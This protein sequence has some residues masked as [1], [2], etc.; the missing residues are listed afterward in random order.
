MNADSTT[1]PPVTATIRSYLLRLSMCLLPLMLIPAAVLAEG[2]LPDGWTSFDGVTTTPTAPRV[3]IVSSSS[4]RIQLIIS[5]PG[6]LCETIEHDGTDYT[7]LSF[8]EYF[9][10]TETGD[11]ALPAIR[12]LL[13]V[14]RGC[15]INVSTTAMDS[16]VFTDCVVYPV[17][18]EVVRYTEEGWSYVDYEFALNEQAY[19]RSGGYPSPRISTEA[20][21]SFRGQ[22]VVNLTSYPVRFD[23]SV[24]E[25][26]VYPELLVTLD[27]SG[28]SGGISE[29]LGP[30]GRIA[31]ELLLGYAGVGGSGSRISAGDGRWG[32]HS[33]VVSCADSFTDYL[34]IV[35][36]SLMVSPRILQLAEHRAKYNGYNVAVVPRTA[37][38]EHHGQGA[39]SDTAIHHFIQDLYLYGEGTAEHM[40]DGR[41]GYVLLVGDAR[42][43]DHNGLNT[44]LPAHEVP[45]GDSSFTTDHWYAC[46]DG[47]TDWYPDLMIGRLCASDTTEL[48]REVQKFVS[49]ETNASSSDEWRSKILLTEGFCDTANPDWI[50]EAHAAFDSIQEILP[51]SW[52]PAEEAH[53]NE[54][55]SEDC[56]AQQ[57]AVRDIHVDRINS[58]VHLLELCAHG[59]THECETF[60]WGYVDSLE[61]DAGQWPFWMNLSCLTGAYDL[62]NDDLTNY[63]CLG[64]ALMHQKEIAGQP[65]GA[66]CFFGASEDSGPSWEG[67]GLYV[68]QGLFEYGH[69]RIGDFLVF[70][71]MKYLTT[72][73]YTQHAIYYN[74]LGDPA[75]DIMLTDTGGQGYSSAPD[76]S[77]RNGDI[78]LVPAFPSVGETTTVAVDVHNESN[79]IPDDPVDVLFEL[80]NPETSTWDSLDTTQVWP[81]DWSSETASVQWATGPSDL[82]RAEL[83]VRVD[84]EGEQDE[85]SELNN[86][87]E[88]TVCVYIERDGFPLELGGVP[89]VAPLAV[90]ATSDAGLEIIS[91][92]VAPG[93]IVIVTCDGDT[94]WSKPAVSESQVHGPVAVGDINVDGAPEAVVSWG[95]KIEA[96]DLETGD[97]IGEYGVLTGLCGPP[98]LADLVFGTEPGDIEIVTERIWERFLPQHALT[99]IASDWDS[100]EWNESAGG[101]RSASPVKHSPTVVDLDND[102]LRDVVAAYGVGQYQG[103][104]VEAWRGHDGST[105]WSTFVDAS[106]TDLLC[107]VVAAEVV[108]DS[109]GIE[110]LCGTDYLTCLSSR[111]NECWQLELRGYA[112]GFAIGDLTGDGS[113]EIVTGTHINF[114]SLENYAGCL[115]VVD[116]DGTVLDSLGLGGACLAQPVLADLDADGKME[117]VVTA[118]HD[119]MFWPWRRSLTELHVFTFDF[120]IPAGEL[121]RHTS[122]PHPLLFWSR[123]TASP[124]VADTDLDG[125]LEIWIADGE[126][127]LHCL[128]LAQLEAPVQGKLSRWTCFQ[129]DERHTGVYETP[130]SG[131]YPENTDASWWGDYLLTGDV[132]IDDTSSLLVQA[133]TTVRVVEGDDQQSGVD[134]GHTELIVHGDMAAS[135]D[136]AFAPTVF[137]SAASEPS[138]GNW[139]GIRVCEDGT[140][141]IDGCTVKDAFIGITADEPYVVVVE[142]CVIE[143]CEVAGI[144]C[145]GSTLGSSDIL[146]F[147]NL[148][149]GAQTGIDLDKCEA[150]VDTNTITYCGSYGIN[151]T[152]DR[153]SDITRNAISFPFSASGG[154]FA[155]IRL[156][157]QSGTAYVTDNSITN[158]RS[159]GITCG[160]QGSGKTKVY[161]TDNTIL[162]QQASTTSKGMYFYQSKAIPRRNHI[163]E[164]RDGFWIEEA[165]GL[166][167]S[168]NLGITMGDGGYNCVEGTW[169]R[170]AVRADPYCL[171]TVMA[172]GNWW[173][174][175]NPSERLFMGLVDWHPFVVGDSCSIGRGSLDQHVEEGIPFCLVQ[176]SPNPFNP[177]TSL[178]FGLPARQQVSLSIYNV[179]GRRVTTLVDDTL[180]PGWHD[181]VWDGRDDAHHRVSSGVYFCRLISQGSTSV[182]KVVLLK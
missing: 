120:D 10:S 41:L 33:T 103:V 6:M 54:Q 152:W 145:E 11:P 117:I 165:T 116:G 111:G 137:G 55:G 125:Y 95:T 92:S 101:A 133:G 136:G 19:S 66:L 160:F 139:Y 114:T 142:N 167:E 28:G 97:S 7:R 82:G 86:E 146:I 135:G 158:A 134:I 168:P 44:L 179:A 14:P 141:E 121:T 181:I 22:G 65:T 166:D 77:V 25:I 170:Y 52:Y 75:I 38:A 74:L 138:P 176:N 26:R 42:D 58:G 171:T 48:R 157:V 107:S 128:D 132:T 79:Y 113:L 60:E 31:E 131:P 169:L 94:V 4:S 21:G 126:G 108:A 124:L 112:A 164:K 129:R 85:L 88:G 18:A 46:V 87:A 84:P 119:E 106:S 2:G 32:V 70:A 156:D 118:S 1:R 35:E 148:I 83:R 51:P 178:R 91:G 24:S 149:S 63:D 43:A 154:P 153:G 123:C 3:Q 30:F 115:Y 34:M 73:G 20:P 27:L 71:K 175:S 49:Y 127:L 80:W 15:E 39:I 12:Q 96:L 173:G 182:K 61:N 5:T 155:G 69:H 147:H 98:A 90:D 130:V 16:L 110:L 62:Y 59:H 76:Y 23:A 102:G 56:P 17:E 8:P 159:S 150:T 180:D 78:A 37:V 140:G 105:L 162:D 47:S 36:D 100:L 29:E 81:G 45:T 177:V 50:V 93:N 72:S 53:A 89:G 163:V 104:R 64:E 122:F 109:A 57:H 151:M 161:I 13:A 143:S 40:L 144:K 172:E 67:L 68:W 9:H 99:V 174:T